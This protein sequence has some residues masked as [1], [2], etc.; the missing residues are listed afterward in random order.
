MDYNLELQNLDKLIKSKETE[1][2]RLEEKL[3]QCET[4]LNDIKVKCEELGLKPEELKDKVLEL[5]TILNKEIVEAKAS[6]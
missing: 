5:E 3:K 6:L 4:E 2:I 1:K